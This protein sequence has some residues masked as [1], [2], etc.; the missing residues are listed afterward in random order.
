MVPYSALVSRMYRTG[1]PYSC[2]TYFFY[3]DWSIFSMTSTIIPSSFTCTF[4]PS[5]FDCMKAPGISQVVMSLR[6]CASMMLLSMR[7][8]MA[9]VGDVLSSFVIYL[10]WGLPSVHLRPFIDPYIRYLRVHL[11]RH[12]PLRFCGPARQRLGRV[13][14]AIRLT[15]H[16]CLCL[17]IF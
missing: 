1:F 10:R 17:Q 9:M 16:V 6:S 11:F 2:T 8:L 13:V 3:F 12:F 5:I 7:A 15:R 14:S 4:F